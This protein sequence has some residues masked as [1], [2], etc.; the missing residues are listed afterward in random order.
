MTK[1]AKDNR[2]GCFIVGGLAAAAAAAL[3]WAMLSMDEDPR[4]HPMADVKGAAAPATGSGEPS[5]P[6]VDP[7][8]Q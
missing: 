8:A 5:E 7:A 2:R 3:G 1:D 4:Q 6:R